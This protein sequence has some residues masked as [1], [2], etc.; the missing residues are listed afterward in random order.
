[1][2]CKLQ[3]TV[4]F[5]ICRETIKITSV[6]VLG[7]SLGSIQLNVQSFSVKKQ[8]EKTF[9]ESTC[10]VKATDHLKTLNRL[11]ENCTKFCDPQER[12]K[13]LEESLAA[14]LQKQ[15]VPQGEEFSGLQCVKKWPTS[16]N[17]NCQLQSR[18]DVTDRWKHIPNSMAARLCGN[19]YF[20]S[21]D[22]GCNLC[23]LLNSH[24][25]NSNVKLLTLSL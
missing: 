20:L 2:D 25:A 24:L 22:G 16:L 13:S 10:S 11:E 7:K 21:C 9:L 15:T 14:K 19:T 12:D 17:K 1:M 4:C 18:G 5:N 8:S 3:A 23:N 6:M